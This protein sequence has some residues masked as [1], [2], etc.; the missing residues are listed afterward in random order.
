MEAHASVLTDLA[1]LLATRRGEGRMKQRKKNKNEL[2]V[3]KQVKRK[4]VLL[5]REILMTV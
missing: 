3:L 4:Q 2:I 1:G 5:V